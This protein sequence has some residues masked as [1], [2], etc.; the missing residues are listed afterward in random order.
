MSSLGKGTPYVAVSVA[1]P[2]AVGSRILIDT[3][4]ERRG[5]RVVA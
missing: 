2:T 1:C 4:T 5:E 3:F